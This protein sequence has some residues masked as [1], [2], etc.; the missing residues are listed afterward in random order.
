[1]NRATKAQSQWALMQV[2]ILLLPQP[3]LSTP[4]RL[5]RKCERLRFGIHVLREFEDCPDVDG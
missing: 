4:L 5:H 3:G 1:M 2:A